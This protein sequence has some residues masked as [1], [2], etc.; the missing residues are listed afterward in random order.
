MQ[1]AICARCGGKIN[2][3]PGSKLMK[4]LN[5]R[6]KRGIKGAL[7]VPPEECGEC[8][9]ELGIKQPDARYRVSGTE[10][11]Y[12]PTLDT[13]QQQGFDWGFDSL[14][15]AAT[16]Y[17]QLKKRGATVFFRDNENTNPGEPTL[18]ELFVRGM[19]KNS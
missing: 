15:E 16:K 14:V 18:I 6:A 3:K 11:V 12:D 2:P 8:S 5:F 9:K 10:D 13:I 4:K 17:L 7:M 1:R 19:G